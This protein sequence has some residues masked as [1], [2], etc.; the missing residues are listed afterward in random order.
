VGLR[1]DDRFRAKITCDDVTNAYL[2]DVVVIG[3][4]MSGYYNAKR[5]NTV[6]DSK[7]IAA[8]AAK[9]MQLDD[10]DTCNRASQRGE[11]AARRA[12]R[13]HATMISKT[14]P[15]GVP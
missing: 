8:N 2:E 9:V 11:I 13:W 12:I 1:R 3:A 4:W 5:D 15:K 14:H 7:Q 6:V 10:C